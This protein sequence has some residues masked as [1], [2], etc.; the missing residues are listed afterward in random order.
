MGRRVCLFVVDDVV[1]VI[2]TW[3]YITRLHSGGQERQGMVVRLTGMVKMTTVVENVYLDGADD[4]NSI[5]DDN[6]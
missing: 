1:I 4:G 2:Q 5:D 6:D 3:L